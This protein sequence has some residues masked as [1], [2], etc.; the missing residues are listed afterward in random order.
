MV[1]K[2]KDNVEY[3]D[4]EVDNILDAVYSAI[5][6]DA[7]VVVLVVVCYDAD[8]NNLE[9]FTKALKGI[10]VKVLIPAIGSGAGVAPAAAASPA[11][12]AKKKEDKKEEEPK[13]SDGNSGFTV[14]E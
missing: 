5:M 4:E 9:F 13:E 12:E 7:I 8:D 3:D 10:N 1:A 2:S 14:F 11:A 6:V